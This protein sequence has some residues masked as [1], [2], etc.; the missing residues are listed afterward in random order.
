MTLRR[1]VLVYLSLVAIA[2]CALTVVVGIVLVRHRVADQ[3]LDQMQNEAL[4]LSVAGG[5]PGARE[6]G[7][8]VYRLGLRTP[9]RLRPRPTRAVLD[10]VPGDGD[11]QGT[12]QVDHVT[13][14]YV[15]RE[16]AVGRIVLVRCCL[17][18]LAARC[19]RRCSRSCSPAA[20]PVPSA[21]SRGRRAASPPVRAR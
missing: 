20:S 5:A 9:R 15:A 16:T 2:S 17:P 7:E 18:A 13:L 6:A 3:R 1:R 12:I 21:R 8:H 4:V 11:G 10:A 14:L 19:S